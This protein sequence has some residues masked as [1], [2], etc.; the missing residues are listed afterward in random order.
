MEGWKLGLVFGIIGILIGIFSLFHYLRKGVLIVPEGEIWIL[1]RFGKFSRSLKPGLHWR[2]PGVE[3]VVGRY[4]IGQIQIKFYWKGWTEDGVGVEGEG[5]LFLKITNPFKLH[6]KLGGV[7][8]VTEILEG[9][10]GDEVGKME[11]DKLIGGEKRLGKEIVG[12]LK[13][14][15]LQWG[16]TPLSFTLQWRLME[17]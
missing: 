15:F 7:E 8:G 6:Y 16:I 9:V 10:L 14:I 12:R 5:V 13:T 4:P 3:R 11:L 2:W 17:K 1:E